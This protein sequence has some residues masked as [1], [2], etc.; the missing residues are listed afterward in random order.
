VIVTD[1]PTSSKASVKEVIF[2]AGAVTT[3]KFVALV[4]CPAT[5]YT[6]IGPSS[7]GRNDVRGQ[8]STCVRRCDEGWRFEASVGA[9]E[10]Q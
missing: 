1:V 5:V 8:A 3:M 10:S 9:V 4:F 2:G 7:S 6:W